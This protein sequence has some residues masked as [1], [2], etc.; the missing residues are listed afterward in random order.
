MSNMTYTEPKL[1]THSLLEVVRAPN[2]IAS[3]DPPPSD[4]PLLKNIYDCPRE[5][6]ITAYVDLNTAFKRQCCDP[7][8]KEAFLQDSNGPVELPHVELEDVEV[9]G[10]GTS[11]FAKR[12]TEVSGLQ[13]DLNGNESLRKRRRVM[14]NSSSNVNQYV[15]ES[16]KDTGEGIPTPTMTSTPDPL[17]LAQLPQLAQ[18]AAISQQLSAIS[19]AQNQI[20]PLQPLQQLVNQAIVTQNSQ[21]LLPLLQTFQTIN[22]TSPSYTP[23]PSM[24][25]QQLLPQN[26]LQNNQNPSLQQPFP[27]SLPP[28]YPPFPPSRPG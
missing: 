22:Q 10:K 11:V 2:F 12:K 28:S 26:Q 25:A 9:E 24:P 18:L 20:N 8:D 14:S 16:R 6:L 5:H 19:A 27:P 23:F 3:L 1:Q 17:Q 15:P 13:G 4:N 21:Q 7:K